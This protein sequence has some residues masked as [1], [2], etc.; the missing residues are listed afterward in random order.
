MQIKSNT[1]YYIRYLTIDT[2]LLLLLVNFLNW[3]EAY[4][5]VLLSHYTHANS[6]MK[7][8]RI[9]FK[10]ALFFQIESMEQ[11]R[12]VRLALFE[13]WEKV[14]FFQFFFLYDSRLGLILREI[15][16]RK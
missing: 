2:F 7:T 5:H 14:L 3:P 8:N 11:F 1:T 16:M 4:V 10:T 13:L 12:I 9:V 6:H 15:C